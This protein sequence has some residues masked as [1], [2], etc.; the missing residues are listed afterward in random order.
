L[1]VDASS[2]G[3][4]LRHVL[5]VPTGLCCQQT[6]NLKFVTGYKWGFMAEEVPKCPKCASQRIWKYGSRRTELGVLRKF[7][8]PQCGHVWEVQALEVQSVAPELFRPI[9]KLMERA[10]G[11]AERGV[12]VR[13]R[14]FEEFDAKT[15]AAL[16]QTG[17]CE[18]DSESGK[19][20]IYQSAEL[21]ADLATFE[22]AK[23]LL[24]VRR[25]EKIAHELEIV[26]RGEGRYGAVLQGLGRMLES[27]IRTTSPARLAFVRGDGKM[28][29]GDWFSLAHK[30][31]RSLVLTAVVEMWKDETEKVRM[32][33]K[34]LGDAVQL[35]E[36]VEKVL[37]WKDVVSRLGKETLEALGFLWFADLRLREIESSVG[38]R[39]VQ[40][41][42]LRV[43]GL[44][45][46]EKIEETLSEVD[47]DYVNFPW[48]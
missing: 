36:D 30:A 38:K 29:S 26:W 44:Q 43:V 27:G 1:N 9:M 48:W 28:F 20:R 39:V 13:Q 15:V 8:C 41:A 33:K 34:I 32:S 47:V 10:V 3:G 24:D 7:L 31:V 35:A 4:S 25:A 19:I 12:P 22:T 40:R 16:V 42:L 23:M 18:R 46:A 6:K 21:P 5:V 14:G 37:R 2:T 45:S 17:L 11:D